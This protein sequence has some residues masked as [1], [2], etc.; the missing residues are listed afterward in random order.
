MTALFFRS[1]GNAPLSVVSTG[2]DGK[3]KIWELNLDAHIYSKWEV[4][5][6]DFG[7]FLQN[8]SDHDSEKG[9]SE[10]GLFDIELD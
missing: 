7:I 2:D 1:Y 10:L 3:F 8:S 6:G 5:L 9:I 4:S